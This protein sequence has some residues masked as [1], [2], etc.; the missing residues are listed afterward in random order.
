MMVFRRSLALGGISGSG[1]KL[2]RQARGEVP[3]TVQV[4]DFIRVDLDLKLILELEDH[5]D[6]VER[7]ERKL[8]EQQGMRCD[9]HSAR[10]C[11]DAANRLRDGGK[12]F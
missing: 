12:H 9:R 7:V 4:R 10:L 1:A 3:D 2:V 11:G 8:F 6:Q 5:R